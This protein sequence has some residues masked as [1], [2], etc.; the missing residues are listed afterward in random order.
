VEIK[1]PATD[2]DF[3]G[4]NAKFDK[5][6]IAAASS[7]ANSTVNGDEGATGS[8]DDKVSG[9]VSKEEEKPVAY[10]PSRSFFDSLSSSTRPSMSTGGENGRGGRGRRGGGFGQSRRDEERE[11]NVATFGEPGGSYSGWGGYGRRGGRSR[12]GAP[13]GGPPQNGMSHVVPA[14]G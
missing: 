8:E 10:N 13:R 5:A 6:A 11:R 3:V 4:S 14:R 2:F 7:K 9:E 12:R 1:V